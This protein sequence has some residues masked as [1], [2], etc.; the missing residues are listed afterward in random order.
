MAKKQVAVK[1]DAA[2]PAAYASYEGPTGMEDTEQSDI[3]IPFINLLQSNSELVE[4]GDAQAGQF[5]NNVMGTVHDEIRFVP[6]VRERVF[7][8]WVPIDDGGGFVGVHEANSEFVQQAIRDNGGSTRDVKVADGKH[9]LVETVQLYALVLGED[10]E[11]ER[12]VIGFTSSKLKAYRGFYS[13]ANSQLVKVGDRK[14]K[15]PI[16]GHV[17]KLTSFHDVA[18]SNGKKFQNFKIAFDGEKAADCRLSP[19]DE[20]FQAGEAFYE[21]VTS[22]KARADMASS[23]TNGSS[24]SEDIPF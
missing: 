3:A 12:A 4:A 23:D 9:D 10:D 6:C 11:Y 2:V 21:M 13:K 22:G 18:K 5:Y 1:K 8:E 14:I 7:I 16:W 17:Y 20:L 24:G 19:D 15:V